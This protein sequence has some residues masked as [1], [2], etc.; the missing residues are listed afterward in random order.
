MNNGYDRVY[1]D[2]LLCQKVIKY[3]WLLVEPQDEDLVHP[4]GRNEEKGGQEV[5]D[6][7]A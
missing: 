2:G 4:V 1:H 5:H 7:H 3:D 6:W